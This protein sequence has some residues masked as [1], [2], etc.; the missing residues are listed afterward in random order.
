MTDRPT[1][2]TRA[3]L[4]RSSLER[5]GAVA[6]AW[7]EGATHQLVLDDRAITFF[8]HVGGALEAAI[9]TRDDDDRW[10][11]SRWC[12][13]A[14]THPPATARRIARPTALTLH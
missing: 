11:V 3:L 14:T 13:R 1:F 12:G 7:L 8:R 9:A 10:S 4:R 5:A 2:D 6:L